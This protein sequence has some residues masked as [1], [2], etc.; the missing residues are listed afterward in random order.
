MTFGERFKQLRVAFGLTQQELADDVNK[1]YGY[2][3]SKSSISQYENDK[4]TP[5]NKAL[6]SFAQYFNV[7]IDYLLG[8]SDNRDIERNTEKHI[9]SEKSLQGICDFFK[10]K[11]INRETKDKF[12][13]AI[14]DSYLNCI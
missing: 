2:T 6:I 1:V 12:F 11:A 8:V 3:F 7:S 4:K 10:D 9:L 5:G 13:K 14:V